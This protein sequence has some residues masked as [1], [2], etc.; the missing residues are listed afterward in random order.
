M[1]V[2]NKKLKVMDTAAISLCM[3]NDI[4]LIIFNL[5]EKGNIKKVVCG[6]T[7]GTIVR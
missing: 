4:P 3:D 2:L 1:D 5:N 7:I 6:K